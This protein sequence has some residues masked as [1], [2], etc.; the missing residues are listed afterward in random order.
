[1]TIS[2]LVGTVIYFISDKYRKND[3]KNGPSNGQVAIDEVEKMNSKGFKS[4]A[5]AKLEETKRKGLL[6]DSVYN[7]EKELINK[8]I[9]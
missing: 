9:V 3:D 5:M 8:E 4:E 1:S 6:S 2:I 7:H